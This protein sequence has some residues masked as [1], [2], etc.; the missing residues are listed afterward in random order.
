[1]GTGVLSYRDLITNLQ[2]VQLTQGPSPARKTYFSNESWG[3]DDEWIY[4]AGM[5]PDSTCP[6]VL[7]VH[8]LSGRL[9]SIIGH[10]A[11]VQG[12]L[13]LDR[14]RD[15]AY[16][17]IQET[18]YQINLDTLGAEPIAQIP[19]GA[20]CTAPFTASLS[21]LVVNS[22]QLAQGPYALITTDP[23]DGTVEI[24]YRSDTPLGH[25][26]FCPGDDTTIFYVHETGGD[27]LQR[28]WMFD[29]SSRQRRPFYVEGDDDW[30]T[31][32]T[33]DATGSYMT[34]IRWPHAIMI[35]DK[36]G[37][38]FQVVARGEFHHCAP[39]PTGKWIVADRTSTGE[40]LLIDAATGQVHT[41][42]TGQKAT[43]GEDHCHPS[44]NRAGNKICFTSPKGPV[45]QIAIMDLRQLTWFT[46]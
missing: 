8:E 12:S 19:P 27:A 7:G 28:M 36:S 6:E 29:L 35:G 23:G 26:Q 14:H 40:I 2:I 33:W 24:I 3:S 38:D 31:H 32:E 5:R 1:M 41:L 15:L 21:G 18:I 46:P 43:R 16:V 42:V 44:F 34:F 45:P 9:R 25:C 10:E 20:R 17:L 39:S 4:F 30:V 22:Y 37:E 11:L 13:G